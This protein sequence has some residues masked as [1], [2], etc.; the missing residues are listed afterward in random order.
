MGADA[1]I[2]IY[3]IKI[4][5]DPENE[6]EWDACGEET[7]SRCLAAKRVGLERH[8]GRMTDGEDYFLFIGHK[9]AW[10]GL[11]HDKHVAQTIESRSS[12]AAE[13]GTKLRAAGFSES[14]GL[15]F[16]FIGQY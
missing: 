15:H 9:V 11:E 4:P 6:D 2:A 13:V 3:G 12:I 10:L 8:S 14:P 7:D 16:Q 1:F 5:L